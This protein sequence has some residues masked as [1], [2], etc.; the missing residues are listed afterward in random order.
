MGSQLDDYGV[1]GDELKSLEEEH[2]ADK[3]IDEIG[4]GAVSCC[5][6]LPFVHGERGTD[7]TRSALFLVNDHL[8]TAK[9]NPLQV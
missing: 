3:V 1:V 5:R 9:I 2:W 8:A 4:A 6:R 7:P